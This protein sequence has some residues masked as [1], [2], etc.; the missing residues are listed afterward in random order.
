MS[1]SANLGTGFERIQDIGI[2]LELEL[3][4]SDYGRFQAIGCSCQ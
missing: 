3:A 1:V 2:I 4:I